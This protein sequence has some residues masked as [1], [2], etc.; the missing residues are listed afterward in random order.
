M[1]QF[2]LSLKTRKQNEAA[3]QIRKFAMVKSL[4]RLPVEW[5]VLFALLVLLA[6]RLAGIVVFV[7]RQ[8]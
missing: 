6:L 3:N 5:Q 7:V 2:L 1:K 4:I 8:F